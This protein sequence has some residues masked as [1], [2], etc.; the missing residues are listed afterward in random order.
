MFYA[1]ILVRNDENKEYQSLSLCT[2]MHTEVPKLTRWP[3][4]DMAI[5]LKES[6]SNNQVDHQK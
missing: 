2:I 1:S 4:G 6:F 3:L 5:V